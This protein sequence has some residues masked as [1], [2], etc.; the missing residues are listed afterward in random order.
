MV[1]LQHELHTGN[2][3]D[4]V[5]TKVFFFSRKHKLNFAKLPPK[6]DREYKK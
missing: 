4:R 6:N 5:G 1:S 2:S 3:L